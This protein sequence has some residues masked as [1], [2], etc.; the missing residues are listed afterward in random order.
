MDRG[1]HGGTLANARD[2]ILARTSKRM[3]FPGM[4]GRV[5]GAVARLSRA[6][7]W[8]A[9]LLVAFAAAYY[10]MGRERTIPVGVAMPNLIAGPM[11]PAEA[12]KT[13]NAMNA[14]AQVEVRN[15][16]LIVRIQTA[17]FPAQR[18]GQLALAQQYAR[19]DEITSGRKRTISFLD[20]DG[21]PFAKSVPG[22]GVVM[23][24]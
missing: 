7:R 5:L 12:T 10:V 11:S 24:R 15:G 14:T 2:A 18:D 4:A 23:T 8:G 6:Q 19:A 17:A 20:P 21:S 22:T 1:A 16:E 13:L 9:I 3:L